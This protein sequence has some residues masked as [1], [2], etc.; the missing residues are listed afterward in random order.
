M[1][2]R[3]MALG[4]GLDALFT[5]AELPVSSVNN[6]DGTERVQLLRLSYIEPR[7]DQ[8]RKVFDKESLAEL[9]DSIMKHG[10][11]QPIIVR[12]SGDVYEIIAGERRWRAAK[13]AGLSEIPAIVRETSDLNAA[14]IA[15]IENLQRE[16][17]GPVEE[18]MGYKYLADNYNLTQE[19]IARTVAKSRSLVANS[20]RLLSLPPEI[21]EYVQQNRITSGHA[22]AILSVDDEAL[23]HT[24]AE[25]IMKNELS[26]RET[27]KLAKSFAAGINQ[28]EPPQD[29]SAASLTNED[30]YYLGLEEKMARSLG[31]KIHIDR[32]KTLGAQS[33]RLQIAYKDN[34]QL[35]ALIRALCGE[36]FE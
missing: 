3:K 36:I 34:A 5:G 6:D 4:K 26:V 22:R 31:T 35:E 2:T 13:I 32:S 21:L 15:L 8:P 18:A 17:L 1:P 27:E 28:S 29:E 23:Q 14:E 11:L 25:R 30:R 20:M 12:K 9:A 19:D 10:I 33:G 24:L 7:K 16:D